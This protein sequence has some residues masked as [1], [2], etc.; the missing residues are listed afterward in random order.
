MTQSIRFVVPDDEDC[1]DPIGTYWTDPDVVLRHLAELDPGQPL[2]IRHDV[3]ATIDLAAY[4]NV[5]DLASQQG[6]D[7]VIKLSRE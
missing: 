5:L 7:V 6:R 1:P 3:A 4:S 2:V